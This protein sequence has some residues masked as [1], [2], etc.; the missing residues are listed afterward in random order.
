MERLHATGRLDIQSHGFWHRYIVEETPPEVIRE[1]L[2]APIPILAEHFGVRP[3][4]LIWPG[5]NFTPLSVR[6]AREAGFQI[7][8]T[9]FARGPLMFNWIP[10]G[11]EERAIDDPLM[12]L[13]RFWSPAAYWKLDQ[14]LQL[15]RSASLH[16]LWSYHQEA[17][18]FQAQC[19]GQ[20]PPPRT[21]LTGAR[22]PT[23]WFR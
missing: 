15:S 19:G 20:L 12:T 1:E 18:W 5:G 14:A 13:P 17:H 7:A 8:F 11:E 2:Y 16:A 23:L 9:A 22:K 4:A 3:I 10:V 21:A 6:M